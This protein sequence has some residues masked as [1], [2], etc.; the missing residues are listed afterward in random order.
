MHG[1]NALKIIRDFGLCGITCAA[2][3]VRHYKILYDMSYSISFSV[4]RN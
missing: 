4:P 3:L 1:N 2:L